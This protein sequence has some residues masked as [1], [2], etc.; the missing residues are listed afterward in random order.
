[1]YFSFFSRFFS[2][3][4]EII[5]GGL[6]SKGRSAQAGQS[7]NLSFDFKF[8]KD[9]DYECASSHRPLLNDLEV[10]P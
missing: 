5:V 10:S 3:S 1:M 9:R 7:P 6:S 4:A 8:S 2:W